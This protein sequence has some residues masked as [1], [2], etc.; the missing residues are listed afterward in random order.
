MHKSNVLFICVHNSARSQMAEKDLRKFGSD[1]FEV[2]SAGFEPTA[3]NHLVD[4]VLKE[5]GL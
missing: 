3:V 4:E 2:K 5:D 1:R